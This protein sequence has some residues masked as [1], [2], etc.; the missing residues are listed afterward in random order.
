MGCIIRWRCLVPTVSQVVQRQLQKY[1][2]CLS[3]HDVGNYQWPPP[4]SIQTA[5]IGLLYLHLPRLQICPSVANKSANQK[6][7]SLNRSQWDGC[8]TKYDTS[9]EL[10]P[11][12]VIL[13]LCLAW[14]WYRVSRSR[15]PVAVALPPRT[16]GRS[17][18]VCLCFPRLK[19]LKYL[20]C[21][22]AF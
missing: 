22:I 15:H 18:P 16:P 2:S 1:S 6:A 19:S 7:Y 3:L 11:L 20:V 13:D 12:R 8:S 9:R 14:G 5:D 10:C 4:A 21:L 17:F